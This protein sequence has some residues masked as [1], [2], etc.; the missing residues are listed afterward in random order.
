[1]FMLGKRLIVALMVL[2]LLA[3]CGSNPTRDDSA[4][5]P[6]GTQ[7]SAAGPD[8]DATRTPANADTSHGGSGCCGNFGNI[9]NGDPRILLGLIVVV[10]VVVSAIVVYHLAAETIDSIRK[11]THPVSK[12]AT[13]GGV[14]RDPHGL[15][16]VDIPVEYPAQSRDRFEVRQPAGED[17]QQV[18]FITDK[19]DDP[20]YGISVQPLASASDATMPL[21]DFASKVYPAPE[22]G[23]AAAPQRLLPVF[24]QAITLDGKPALFREYSPGLRPDG[25]HPLYYL[26]YFVRDAR[27]SAVLSITWP[28]DCPSCSNG[29]EAAIRDTDSELRKFVGSF[30]MADAAPAN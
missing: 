16:S 22:S 18:F 11:H 27:H 21:A 24:E 9:G 23:D 5:A 2:M 25:K 29:P 19:D 12:D 3:G 10:V 30:H 4:P 17:Q 14:Y 26:L 7:T 28:R 6:Q 15:F 20:V 8:G 1:M 13:E